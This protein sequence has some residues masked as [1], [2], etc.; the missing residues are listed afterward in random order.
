MEARQWKPRDGGKVECSLCAHRCIIGERRTG[1]CGVR[2]NEKG[3]LMANTYGQISSMGSDPIEKKPFNHFMPGTRAYSFGSVGCNLQCDFCQNFTISQE[4]SKRGLK[5]ITP[6]EVPLLAQKHDCQSVEWTYNEPTIWFEFTMDSCIQAHKAGI[7]TSYVTNGYMTEEALKEIGPHLDAMN[8]DV[9]AFTDEFYLKYSKAHLQPVLDT[10][11]LAKELGIHIELAMLI[12]PGR[13]DDPADIGRYC[14]WVMDD[15]GPETPIHFSAFHPDYKVMDIARTPTKTLEKAHAIAKE[16]GIK[17]VYLGNVPSREEEHTFC[18]ECGQI[19]IKRI[20]YH[21][22]RIKHDNGKC[23][24][25]GED[26]NL[27]LDPLGK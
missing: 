23:K 6:V 25:C 4:F 20:G 17:F 2:K 21:I 1:I 9:K 15:L 14:D 3:T 13:N 26:L 10:C 8:I 7:A 19:A 11:V 5:H 18:P 12:I 24:S 27:V 22:L 16:K